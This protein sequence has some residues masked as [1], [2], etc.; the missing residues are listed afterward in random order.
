MRTALP[1]A[2]FFGLT[3][4]PI[5]DADRNTFKLFG[6]PDDPGYILNQYSIERSIADGSSV[7]VHVET[8]LVEFHIDKDA[9]DEA[10]DGDGRGGGP[11][12][13]GAGAPRRQ[14]DLNGDLHAQP[15]AHQTR[16]APTS[17]T[18]TSPKVAPL[19]MKAQV[20][21]FDRELCVAYHREI[22]RILAERGL[23]D[24][25][26]AAVVMTVGTAKDEPA[27][28]QRLRADARPGGGSSR[29]AFATTTT[30]CGS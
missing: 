16:S 9:L 23:A 7:P 20:V 6:D 14:G 27:E 21:A 11:H 22:S 5:S 3:G 18:T 1:N 13:R 4:T 17:S 30:R 24:E 26:E 19:G 2:Q 15:R 8:R 29:H 12:R 10:F 28:W 25:A